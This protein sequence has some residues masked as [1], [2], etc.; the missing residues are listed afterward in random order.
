MEQGKFNAENVMASVD[1]MKMLKPIAHGIIKNEFPDIVVRLGYEDTY[2]QGAGIFCSVISDMR[3]CEYVPDE[4]KR[5]EMK[6][7]IKEMMEL[8]HPEY[9][10]LL[11][12][13]SN[14]IDRDEND[15]FLPGLSI[16]IGA[17][18][19]LDN[20]KPSHQVL[21]AGQFYEMV[22]CHLQDPVKAKLE[23]LQMFEIHPDENADIL[24][25]RHW[26]ESEYPERESNDEEATYNEVMRL[27]FENFWKTLDPFSG[28]WL[29]FVPNPKADKNVVDELWDA[30]N[31]RVKEK[32]ES[33]EDAD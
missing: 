29:K 11:A 25:L 18:K 12:A 6:R 3:C 31:Q 10:I 19:I 32:R 30:A 33:A 27:A 28:A 2:I 1:M 14:V 24:H 13:M 22:F 9:A 15:S 7:L 4:E 20:F 26:D 8:T 17:A 5:A 21:A 16:I 23:L